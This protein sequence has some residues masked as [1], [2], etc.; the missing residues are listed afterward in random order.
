MRKTFLLIL[1]SSFLSSIAVAKEDSSFSADLPNDIKWE[2][3]TT[4][5]PI[6]DPKAI[7][8]GTLYDY[9][10][11]YPL[12]FRLMGPNSNDSFASWNRAYTMDFSLVNRHPTTD[13][14]I[15]WMATHWSIQPDNQT[16]FYKLDPDAKWSDGKPVTADDYVFCWEMMLSEFIVDPF[17]NNHA[18]D[19]YQSVEKID[20]YTLK[21]V[22]AKPS[23]RP[24]VDYNLFPMPKHAIK[25]GPDWVKE[26][27]NAFQLAV[28]PYV[29]SEAEPG[30][31]VVF[32]RIQN[33]WG[34]KKHYFKGM[35][36]VEKIVLN[37][38]PHER[39]LDYFKKGE[40]SFIR[41][42]T[43]KIWAEELN[44]DALKKG[45]AHKKR[46]FVEY[47]SGMYGLHTNLEAPIFQNK[48]FRKAMQYLFPFETINSKLMYDSYYRQVSF[49]Q[50]TEYQN[51]NLKPYGFDPRKAREH[52]QKAG[53][54]KRGSD[55]ILVD[56][57]GRRASFSLIYGSKSI[58][59]HLTV[60]QEAY[61]KAGVEINLNL[62]EGATAFNRGLERKYEM[63]LTSRTS[64]FYPDPYQYFHSKFKSTTNNNNIWG[65]GAPETDKLIEIYNFNMDKSK[66][67]EA[68]YK[69]D[70]II[71]DEAFY[72][73]FWDAPYIRILYWDYL[74]WPEFF[75]PKRTQQ[76]T[77]WQVFWI[78][79]Q[80][81]AR[82]KTAMEKGE[83]LGEDAIVDIDP[84]G[85][86]MK[87]ETK[88]P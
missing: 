31:R 63:T 5:P 58:E 32:S 44:F 14:F 50:G 16:V 84:Y 76:I 66:R 83:N 80:K 12:T 18:K 52:L 41:V 6:G 26:A 86:K 24:L 35:Y 65:F 49:F 2:T 29:V 15:P 71:Y 57:S 19:Y 69:L 11:D 79:P 4:D 3:N 42:N 59:R 39:D 25:L 88:Q 60:V 17:Y 8:G 30:R 9:M 54:T 23:W 62:L 55:G 53:F 68:M 36:N 78:D 40:L 27:N 64:G 7:K 43:A 22:G 56:Q 85:V 10:E 82:L 13:N 28:G 48:D 75:L 70:E 61:K 67:L 37:L 74:R 73:P 47:P 1:L 33:W 45:W 21:I 20:D 87:M 46:I 81:K 51:P 72:I 34:D 77:D 38:L